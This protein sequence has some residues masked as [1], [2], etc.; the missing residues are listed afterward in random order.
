MAINFYGMPMQPASYALNTM[1]NLIDQGGVGGEV[2]FLDSEI[3]AKIYSMTDIQEQKYKELSEQAKKEL[4]IKKPD[5]A[6]VASWMDI[7]GAFISGALDTLVEFIGDV[8]EFAGNYVA[9]VVGGVG[10]GLGSIFEA[11][12]PILLIGGIVAAVIFLK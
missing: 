7:A 1:W 12:G 9:A 2:I 4:D 8:V 10:K 6:N 5:P 11:A 3:S